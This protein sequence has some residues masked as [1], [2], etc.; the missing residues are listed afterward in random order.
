ME[1]GGRPH[2]SVVVPAFNEESRLGGSLTAIL[3][4][5]DRH[6]LH[7]EVLVV[8]DGSADGTQRVADELL[9]FP[10]GRVLRND[11]NRGKG[12]SVRRAVLESRGRWVLMTD[13]DLSTPIEEHQRL[14]AAARDR[15]LD[16]VIGSRGLPD[17]QVEV[18]QSVMRQTMGRSF[19]LLV[20]SI[21]GLPFRDTQC[22]F[23][24]LD[25]ER[26]L[27]IFERMFV[28]G[29]AFD[30]EL[31]YVAHRFGLRIA[32]LP[33]VWR[34]SPGSTVAVTSAPPAMLRDVLRVLWRF[35]RGGYAPRSD[36][37]PSSPA[38]G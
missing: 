26:V 10:R 37:A 22:G 30:V 29:F 14:A 6:K 35:R 33:V 17:S 12:F 32:E 19:N 31:L 20:R 28:D 3:S 1:A 16:I 2:L 8:D 25:R 13:A 5:L 9:S 21:T 34:N 18:R 23:K 11:E 15:D 27:K 36:A 4:Y 7:A 24:L 38:H